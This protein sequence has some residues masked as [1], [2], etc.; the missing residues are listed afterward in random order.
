M[1]RGYLYCYSGNIDKAIEIF[2][3]FYS[4]VRL[5]YHKGDEEEV[6]NCRD[7]HRIPGQGHQDEIGLRTVAALVNDLI[8]VNREQR[9]IELKGYP[10]LAY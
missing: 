6:F 1:K 4:N 9:S 7:Q 3:G 10:Q 2:H 8:I 5:V